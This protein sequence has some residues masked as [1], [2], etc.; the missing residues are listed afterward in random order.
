MDGKPKV[1][2]GFISEHDGRPYINCSREK[3]EALT[4][5]EQYQQIHHEFASLAGLERNIGAD[6][7]YSISKQIMSYLDKERLTVKQQQSA[8]K[9]AKVCKDYIQEDDAGYSYW[10]NACGEL[11]SNSISN[12][13]INGNLFF[14]HSK[15]PS[16]VCKAHGFKTSIDVKVFDLAKARKEKRRELRRC[17]RD[18][19]CRAKLKE[20][21]N[22]KE[23]ERKKQEKSSLERQLDAMLS[24]PLS[25]FHNRSYSVSN[26]QGRCKDQGLPR[27]CETGIVTEITCR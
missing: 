22:D 2:K 1:C 27:S 11:N 14:N 23:I 16:M 15:I 7:D 13:T 18:P 12:P 17:K 20:S 26:Y 4:L 19:V 3:F 5:P 6:S 25:S 9:T 21:L 24:W 10:V 8:P